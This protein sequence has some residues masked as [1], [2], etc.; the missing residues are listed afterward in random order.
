MYIHISMKRI[1]I[2]KTIKAKMVKNKRNI[3]GANLAFFNRYTSNTA[4]IKFW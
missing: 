4:I 3:I 2:Y 1:Y